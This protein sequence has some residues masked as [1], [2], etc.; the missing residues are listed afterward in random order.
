M[1]HFLPNLFVPGAAKSGTTTLHEMLDFH[2]DICMSSVKE[3]VYWNNPEFINF[4][5]EK[6]EWYHNLFRNKEVTIKGESTPSYM[7]Y[8]DFIKNVKAHFT[9]TPKFIF[10]LRNPIDRAYS[11]YWWMVG[12]GLEK[13]ALEKAFIKDLKKPFGPYDYYPNHYYHFGLYAK[14]LAPFFNT[15]GIENIKIITLEKLIENR[16]KTLNGCF[17]FLELHSLE[18]IPET[19]ANKTHRLNFP[20]LFHLNKKIIQGRYKTPKYAK[21]FISKRGVEFIRARLRRLTILEKSNEFEY[22]KIS[23]SQREWIKHYYLADFEKLLELTGLDFLEWQDF[24]SQ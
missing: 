10:I 2:P 21:Y 5:E 4:N 12:L 7:V 6:K 8:P 22:P 24:K 1:D 3:P 14:W 16:V 20:K 9:F 17:E 23:P 18:N 15:F 13:N 19:I 11:H